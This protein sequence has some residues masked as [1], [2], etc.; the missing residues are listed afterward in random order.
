MID[1][2]FG[3][4]N[5][6]TE[7]NAS[8]FNNSDDSLIVKNTS[9]L[10]GMLNASWQFGYYPNTRTFAAITPFATLSF[11]DGLE[12]ENANV[13]GINSGVQFN[14]YY[15]IS[16]RVRLTIN[17]RFY[18]FDNFVANVPTPFWNTVSYNSSGYD[19]LLPESGNK[20]DFS[21]NNTPRS[22]FSYDIGFALTYAIF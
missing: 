15:Y 1:F 11:F 18:Y 16:P 6:R 21:N 4:E 19:V 10:K 8:F 14:S 12:E 13:I 22:G 17:L 7:N 9:Y 20:I 5:E 2:T 3:Y